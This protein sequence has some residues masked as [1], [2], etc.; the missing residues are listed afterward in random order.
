MAKA[1][2]DCLAF[3]VFLSNNYVKDEECVK[4]FKFAI[5]TLG[6]SPIYV[7]I[8][9]D[10]QWKSGKTGIHFSDIVSFVNTCLAY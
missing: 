5:L 1:L 10:Y 8:G 3:V 7:A 2:N 4:L 9:E 6:K